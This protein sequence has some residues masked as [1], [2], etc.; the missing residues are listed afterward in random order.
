M[1]LSKDKQDNLLTFQNQKVYF[2]YQMI[3]KNLRNDYKFYSYINSFPFKSYQ[4][5]FRFLK[6]RFLIYLGGETL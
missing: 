1:I 6:Y 3:Y 2:L 4:Y 5:C